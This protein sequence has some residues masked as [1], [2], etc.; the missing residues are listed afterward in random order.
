MG[1]KWFTYP[2]WGDENFLFCLSMSTL[3][4]VTVY[5]RKYDKVTHFSFPHQELDQS[6][7]FNFLFF[8]MV[9]WSLVRFSIGFDFLLP[10]WMKNELMKIIRWLQSY[11]TG[12]RSLFGSH[13]R[14]RLNRDKMKKETENRENWTKWNDDVCRVSAFEL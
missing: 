2:H 7:R 9:V 8:S 3:F 6:L 13:L 14:T 11:E 12:I 1:E 10:V 5:K 4:T